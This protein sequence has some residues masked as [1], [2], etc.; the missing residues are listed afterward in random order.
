MGV[1]GLGDSVRDLLDE[2]RE[3]VECPSRDEWSDICWGV[4]R[5][6]GSLSNRVYVHIPGDGMH[7]GKIQKRMSEYGCV[8]SR[9]HLINGKCPNEEMVC[10]S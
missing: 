7:I 5:L 6:I 9:A 2:I 10:K 3:W 8:R 1:R 4:G